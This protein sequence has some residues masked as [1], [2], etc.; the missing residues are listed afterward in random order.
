MARVS[1]TSE[2]YVGRHAR[3]NGAKGSPTARSLARIS[4]KFVFLFKKQTSFGHVL[5]QAV[6]LVTWGRFRLGIL[7]VGAWVYRQTH[8]K[9]KRD[10]TRE[11]CAPL[12]GKL[13]GGTR[14]GFFQL[15]RVKY[16]A[17]HLRKP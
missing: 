12:S 16:A 14:V 6:G 17:D 3:K 7:T 8:W 11:G 4:A 2:T 9:W 13:V 1:N 5:A 15:G 10:D